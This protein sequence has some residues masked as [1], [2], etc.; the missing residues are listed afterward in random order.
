VLLEELAPLLIELVVAFGFLGL[1]HARRLA[2]APLFLTALSSETPTVETEMERHRST[3]LL[4]ALLVVALVAG[5][6]RHDDDDSATPIPQATRAQLAAA[7]LDELPLAPKSKRV[8]LVAPPFSKPTTVANP[9]FPISR[10]RSAI[11]NGS[12]EDKP[13]KVETTL[14]RGTRIIGWPKGRQVETLVSQYVAYLDGR[15]EE[16]ALDFYAQADDG[17]VWYFG[18][19]VFNYQDGLI[20]DTEGTWIAGK[21]GPPAMIMPA[22]PQ[23][24]DV[25][26]PENI[27]GSVFEEVTVKSVGEAVEGPRGAVE[28]A[29]IA[30][31]LHQD[32]MREDKTFAPGYGEFFT[33]S[34]GDIEALA[35]AV[36][37][38]RLS[39]PVPDELG[40]LSAG[41][42]DIFDQARSGD[43]QAT[44]DAVETMTDAWAT[45]RAGD[46]PPRLEP[47]TSGALEELVRAVA[48]R[49]P[50]EAQQAA[51]DV[52]QAGLDLQLRHRPPAEIDRARFELWARQL[53][54][55]AAAD[56]L[57]A[58]SGD[59]ATLE[60]IRDRFVHTLSKVETTRIDTHL[61]EL[62]TKVADEELGEA[63]AEAERL[64]ERVG[65]L[66]G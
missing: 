5:G 4:G 54:V 17:S 65:G 53:V 14:L 42:D 66:L 60:W 29:I 58:V 16:V 9:L 56:D 30:E 46:V 2:R 64:R 37:T 33:G 24:G 39:G 47:P 10:L 6:C 48:A 36:P 20:G 55:D 8:D 23:L 1:G 34:G 31:E 44:R 22:D 43:W 7:N 45:F 61:V 52:A 3:I 12:V 19:D 28:G 27:P 41:A 21:D 25:Y 51:I 50:A 49:E 63:A 35:L 18:E 15:I 26:R 11:L 59:L 57:A 32:G 13:F 62:R 40:T 38:D